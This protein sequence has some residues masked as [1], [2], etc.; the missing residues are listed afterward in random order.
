MTTRLASLLLLAC[1]V[2]LSGAAGGLAGCRAEPSPRPAP[3]P[4]ASPAPLPGSALAGVVRA[5][6]TLAAVQPPGTLTQVR[7]LRG[8]TLHD[9]QH[10]RDFVRVFLELTVYAE[11]AARAEEAYREILAAL[12]V[13]ARAAERVAQASEGRVRR[14]LGE[15]DWDP[16]GREDL[17]SYSD[18]VR[19]EVTLGRPAPAE[20]REAGGT[21]SPPTEPLEAYV[22]GQASLQGSVGQVDIRPMAGSG[23]MRWQV[24]GASA[25]ARYR[26]G[27]IASFLVALEAGSPAVRVTR[28]EMQRSPFEPDVHAPR[29]WTFELEL[30]AGV[31]PGNADTATRV[32][33][34]ERR[35]DGTLERTVP[36]VPA[37]EPA[38]SR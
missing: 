29:G 20:A 24:R 23:G 17:V 28:I 16:P 34:R 5:L 19:L 15:L 26:R 3:A 6:E 25:S 2:T 10:G 36:A 18:T 35:V 31:L 7:S 21:T 37:G 1:S 27:E 12:E 30:A 11:S 32:G 9:S 22:R 4:Q 13:E 14:V 8:D 33:R 38:G